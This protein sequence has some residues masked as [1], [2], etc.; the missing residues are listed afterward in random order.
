MSLVD[1]HRTWFEYELD[2]HAKTLLA[3]DSVPPEGRDRRYQ[4]ALDHFA[5]LMACRRLW[6]HRIGAARTGLT[7]AAEIFPD[8]TPRAALDGLLEAMTADWRPYLES[9][10]HAELGRDFDYASTEGDRY[11]NTVEDILT[12]LFGHAWHHRGQI[13]ALVRECGGE[14]V[15]ADF[16]FWTRKSL[17]Q[18][19]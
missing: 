11:S 3:I 8:Q 13:M 12:Q 15:T 9:L 7:T 17:D 16:V 1:R 5:H 4:K 18:D 2:A 19:P 10:D 6:L 14:P